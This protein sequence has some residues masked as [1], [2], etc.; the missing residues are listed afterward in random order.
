MKSVVDNLGTVTMSANPAG[1]VS[2]MKLVATFGGNIP[3]STFLS[4]V[5][6]IDQNGLNVTSDGATVKTSA[7][8]SGANTCTVTWGFSGTGFAIPGGLSY[9][10]T[11]RINSTLIPPEMGV[12]ETLTANIQTATSVAYKD[13]LDGAAITANVPP[14]AVPIVINTVT[15][16]VGQ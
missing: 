8:C 14:D 3:S 15:Y 4:G 7:P 11:L 2:L 6:L 12:A 13:G 1:P 16:P 9:T 10:F 5:S